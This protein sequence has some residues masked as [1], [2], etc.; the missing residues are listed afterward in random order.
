MFEGLYIIGVLWLLIPLVLL[1]SHAI[2]APLRDRVERRIA[3]EEDRKA[4]QE[5]GILEDK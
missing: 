5:I 4:M 3:D 1:I 2:Q